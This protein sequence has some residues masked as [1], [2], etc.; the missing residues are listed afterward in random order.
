LRANNL[1]GIVLTSAAKTEPEIK[2]NA[3]IEIGYDNASAFHVG[4]NAYTVEIGIGDGAFAYHVGPGA[5]PYFTKEQAEAVAAKVSACGSIDPAH[6]T[7]GYLA[8]LTTAMVAARPV[9]HLA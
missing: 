7:D 4:D 6:W 8:P 9:L 3:R 5:F 1:Y 2:M